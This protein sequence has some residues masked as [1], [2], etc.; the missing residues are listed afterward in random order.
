MP[1]EA[2]PKV[3]LPWA[4]L[5]PL[6]AALAGIIAQY[7]PLVSYR[8]AAAGQK[9]V[10]NLAEQDVDSRL[11]QDPL[12]AARNEQEAHEQRD[13]AVGQLTQNQIQR[14][15]LCS[16]RSLIKERTSKLPS[17]HHTLL[18]AVMIDA[19]P[20]VEES[21]SRLR[22]RRAVLEG[23]GQSGFV[24]KDSEHIGF[25]STDWPL[26]RPIGKLLVPWEECRAA[27][28]PDMMLP[29]GTDTA[30]VLWLPAA[31]F[32]A[33]PL[34]RF[35]AL[36]NSIAD[37]ADHE[38]SG[39]GTD[40]KIK[41]VLIGPTNSDGLRD[42]LGEARN[43]SQR[44]GNTNVTLSGVSIISPLASVADDA[45]LLDTSLQAPELHLSDSPRSVREIIEDSIHTSDFHFLRTATPDNVLLQQLVPELG[46]RGVNVDS[47]RIVVLTEWDSVYGRWLGTYIRIL[48][49]KH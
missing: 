43:W 32:A 10:E 33:N 7:R 22:S 14:H 21:E 6:I 20:Y 24:P 16:L 27:N 1:D 48:G 30:F 41:V 47:D 5:L 34:A 40:A 28:R 38:R 39:D 46:L 12:I 29:P 42:M 23:L 44:I 8:P 17:G 11:W 37:P 18:I 19:G 49:A 45:L 13:V 15:T 26:E 25:V 35:A 36:L 3:E 31:N 4:T 2:K 9:S